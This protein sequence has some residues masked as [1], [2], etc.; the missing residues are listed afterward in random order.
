MRKILQSM[1]DKLV[2]NHTWQ[3]FAEELGGEYEQGNGTLRHGSVIIPRHDYEVHLDYYRSVELQVAAGGP[4]FWTAV[5]NP[6]RLSLQISCR[7]PF[8]SWLASEFP[9]ETPTGYAIFDEKIVVNCN[10]PDLVDWLFCEE[11]LRQS[12]LFPLTLGDKVLFILSIEDGSVGGLSASDP[13]DVLTTRWRG[14]GRRLDALRAHFYA[15][16]AVL[17]R[18][19]PLSDAVGRGRTPPTPHIR[20]YKRPTREYVRPSPS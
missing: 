2:G 14:A 12:L 3:R 20:R 17:D 6:N 18:L 10:N 9:K 5:A 19:N 13:A 11:E 16:T 8:D 1:G 15:H 7:P 4:R